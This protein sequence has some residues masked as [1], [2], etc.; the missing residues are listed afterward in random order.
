MRR[1]RLALALM[2]LV[3]AGLVLAVPAPSLALSSETKS[4]VVDVGAA[5]D[6]PSGSYAYNDVCNVGDSATQENRCAVEFSL[7]NILSSAQI[8]SAQ[9]TFNKSSGCGTQD[10]PVD[11]ALYKGNG[12]ADL[13]DVTDGSVYKT[14]TPQFSNA[15][16]TDLVSQVQTR[17]TNGDDYLGI[18]LSRNSGSPHSQDVQTF[19]YTSFKLA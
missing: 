17:V 15:I 10:C 3:A 5:R 14:F 19:S 6:L 2:G 18:R 7:T 1:S 4:I 9:L 13:T 16:Q 8:L 12:S 11:L